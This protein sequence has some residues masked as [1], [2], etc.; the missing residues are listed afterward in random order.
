[1]QIKITPEEMTRVA[2]RIRQLSDK[3]DDMAQDIKRIISSIDWELRSREGV[4]QKASL[5]RAA[6]INIATGLKEMSQD[7][8]E[9]RD[10]MIEADNKA[11]AAAKKMKTADFISRIASAILT[12]NG[13]ASAIVAGYSL[14]NRLI[15]PG[16]ANCPNTFAGDPV[17]VVSGNFYLK[18]R[19]ITIP[20]RG[21]ALEITRY[22]NSMDNTEGIFGK[23]WKIDYET[24]LKKKEDSED[25]IVAYPDGNIRVFEYTDTGSFKSPKGVYDTL[26]KTEDG[27]Y[28]LKVQKGITYKYDQAGNLISISDSNSNEIQF[29]YNREGLLSS[30]MSPGGKLLMFS[31]EGGRIVS[32]T[33]H[34]GRN[35]KYKYDEKGN[36]TQVV[37]PDGG[38]ITYAYDNIGLISITDQ[39]GNTYVQNTYDEKGRVV[40]QLDHENNEL[41]IEYDEENRENTF[42]WIKSGITRVYKYNTDMLLTEIRYD[43]G[44]VQKYTYDENLNRNSE[45][46]RNGNTTY[47]K[48]DD[49]GNLIEVI[50][51]EPFCYKTKYS[52]NE[53]GRLIK[54]VSPGGGEVSFE[55]DERGNLLKRI[56]KTG[57]RSYSEW[58]YT[59]DQYGRMTTSKDAEN[60]TKT[61]EYG[62]ED[63]NKPTLIKD[64]VGNIFKYEFDK[65]GRVVATT[66]DYG[67]VRMKYNEC[68][69]ITHITDTEGNT[70]RIC[71]DKAG[72]MTKVIAP[73]QYAEKGENGAGYA[74]EY[75]AMDKLIRTIDPLGDVFA[76]KYDENGNKIKEINPNYYSSEKDDGIGIEY[77]YDTNHR[78]INTIFPDGSMSR[79][80]YDAEGNI[81][82]TISWKDY[83]KD[84]D[85]GPGMEY[86]YDEMNRLTQ[87]IDPEGNVIKKYI[88]DEDGRIVKEIDAKGYSSADNDEE[89][90][91]TIYKYN[92][93]GWLVEKRTPL[94][95]KNGEIYYN[96]IEY[97]YDRNG[98]VVKE[99]RSPEYVTR[100]GYPKKWNIIN[101]KYDPNGNLIEVTDSLGAVITYEYDCFGKRTLERMKINDRKQRVTRYEYNG[102]G[103]LTRVIRELDGE[104]LSGYSEDKV[105]AET[106]YNYDQN[107]N[108]VEVISPEGYLTV[109]KYDDANRR[110]KSILYQPQN[111]VKLTGS[112]YCALLNTKARSIS[113]EY[114]RAGNL[115]KQILPN[116][117]VIINEYDEMNRRIRV[118]DPDGNITRIFYDNSGNVV[119]YVDPE[120][121]DTGRDD[122][123]GTTYLYDSMNRLIEIVNAAGIVVERNIYN[124]AGEIIKRIDSVG[125]SSA[126]NDND[127]HGVEF[128]YDLAGRLVE[129]T[130]PEAK[131]HGRK[132]QQYTYDAEGNIT[133]VVDGNGNSTRYSLDLWG[134]IINIT[135]PDGTNIKYD[136]DYAGNLV[137]TTDGNGNTTRYTYNSLN[138]L[139]EIINPDGRKITFKYDRQGRVVQRIGKDGRSTYYTY[140]ADNNITGRWEEEGQMER[141][142]YNI[143]G[144]LAASISG[145]T[146]HTYTYTLAGRLKS[147]TTNGR[148]V[149]EYDY[150]KNGLVSKVTDISG[151]PVEYTYDVL[152][153][154]TAVTNGGKISAKY[155]YNI[156][157]TIA[158]VL[159]GS[160]VCARYE[161]DM[162]KNITRLLNID[163]TG[164]E[165]FAYRY[166]YDGNGNQILKEENEK[167]TAYSYDA[168]NRL[169]EVIYPG[170]I[171][172]RFEY[173]ANGNRLKREY[174]D[175]LEQYEYDNCNRLIQKIKNGLVT[176]YEYDERGNL[177]REREGELSKL[178]SYDGFN[179]LVRVQN[180]DGTYMENIY[181]AENLRTIS[182]ENGKYNRYIYNGRDIACE[183]GEDWSLKDRVV[184]GHTILQKEDGNKNAYYYI[185]NVHGDIT[186]L[187]DGRGEIVNNYSYDAFGNILDSV[188]KVEN[189]FKYS[190]EVLDPLTGQYYLRAR[191]YNPSIGR[192][193][194]EDTFRGDGLNLYTYVANN[195]IKYV[196]PTG[197][198]KEGIEFTDSNSIILDKAQT[199]NGTGN[200][201]INGI[202]TT[203]STFDVMISYIAEKNGGT[204]VY[205]EKSIFGIIVWDKKVTVTIGDTTKVYTIGKKDSV[206]RIVNG[207]AVINNSVLMND[208]GLDEV[209]STHQV[210]DA[211][212]SADHAA[213][214]WGFMYNGK[215]ITDN[216]EYASAIYEDGGKYKY[217]AIIGGQNANVGVPTAPYGK[218]LSAI[219]HAHAAYDK[220]YDNE[221]FSGQDKSVAKFFEV[222]V[223]VTT[224]GGKLKKYDPDIDKTTTINKDMPKDPNSP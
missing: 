6:A 178:Y 4:D 56:V 36:L 20:S 182:I 27:T 141:Y 94:Q 122:G 128:S 69:R 167:V 212:D 221:N 60:N 185:H 21:M 207:K 58:A 188:E 184:R 125:Y 35:L 84:L 149:L 100:T 201:P 14:W 38:K 181:D 33:D 194:Q 169:K 88:Y 48:Y 117:G 148:K 119:K 3:F 85:D 144:S 18:R 11:S 78:R 162:D 163:P 177:I 49:K 215:S 198:C 175:I 214:A 204:A 193:M 22:Y 80:K 208:F 87:I 166:A 209:S 34:T 10:Q 206:V 96:I 108:L 213:M 176:E 145:T 59:Y 115:V 61:F 82:K 107:G 66:T 74:F 143:D 25:I 187:T 17:N 102:V 216:I 89:R 223:Y 219:I 77:K 165:M 164:K 183:V 7:L 131:I 2:E 205:S 42:K 90:W 112:A 104:D 157:N 113:Y 29:K 45:T 57:S 174:G 130:T 168:L 32:I 136:Y 106:I 116:G 109:F 124:T 110:I 195:P 160:G 40:R 218:T 72:N 93:A 103:K 52:Y 9:A 41:I 97:V 76:V 150:N 161:Y 197:H 68:D 1:M 114:D 75:N 132:S 23:G 55:Y 126:D 43:D 210:G 83:N 65:V 142:E 154:L 46:D 120:N 199:G 39:N 173:D 31:Y 151:T 37:Y 189:R 180:P 99:K 91:G 118:T 95:Q 13:I 19:D 192:F 196:D 105:L 30:V 79:I 64:A 53:E 71:Y 211:F 155:E 8:I 5:A 73:K 200:N 127:R 44:S 81:I 190:G 101:Y 156:D 179:R 171:R 86:T 146:I 24:C 47:K 54:V 62:E 70:T 191:Y 135:E 50:S 203:S 63:V 139:S 133:G 153:R 16:T 129:I 137:S 26:L 224:P 152:G 134:K 147:K 67:T 186:A 159:Y 111:G 217:T 12:G 140:N 138:L 92:L 158:Q 202:D 222:P 123:A 51:P 98:R 172:E 28:I 220:R 121:Y 15:G 170:D